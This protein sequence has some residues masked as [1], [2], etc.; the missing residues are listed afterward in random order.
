MHNIKLEMDQF[1]R[2]MGQKRRK[3]RKLHK[4][5]K[6]D[7]P[8]VKANPEG[9]QTSMGVSQVTRKRRRVFAEE[10]ERQA[11]KVRNQQSTLSFVVAPH[12]VPL[13]GHAPLLKMLAMLQDGGSSLGDGGEFYRCKLVFGTEQMGD[14]FVPYVNG[15]FHNLIAAR[16]GHQESAWQSVT[17][18]PLPMTRATF[19]TKKKKH[20]V[21]LETVFNTAKPHVVSDAFV[22][23]DVCSVQLKFWHNHTWFPTAARFILQQVKRLD[24][25]ERHTMMK[26]GPSAVRVCR[27]VA[28]QSTQWRYRAIKSWKGD[29]IKLASMSSVSMSAAHTVELELQDHEMYFTEHAHRTPLFAAASFLTRM[30]DIMY[31]AVDG[32]EDLCVTYTGSTEAGEEE[33]EEEEEE[34]VVE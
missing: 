5:T 10:A 8:L 12:V 2:A 9:M 6:R 32:G 23:R 27:A 25:S 17:A 1:L 26:D 28:A 16:I 15:T 4:K 30:S 19:T 33:E 22:E 31:G 21:C 11:L 24:D 34:E 18:R 13:L 20:T 14:K 3:S 29:D 7:T